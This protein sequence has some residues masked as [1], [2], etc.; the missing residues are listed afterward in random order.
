M[1]TGCV[2]ED[3]GAYY[4]GGVA[5]DYDGYYDGFYGPYYDGYWGPDGAFYYSG[6]AGHPFVRDEGGHFR[7]DAHAG[8]RGVHSNAHGG[9]HGEEHH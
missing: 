9:M 2:A 4:S 7:H 5:V 6:G 8:F 3:H 1:L